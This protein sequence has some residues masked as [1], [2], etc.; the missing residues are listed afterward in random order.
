MIIAY[1]GMGFGILLSVLSLGIF[2][3][4]YL[5]SWGLL[6]GSLCRKVT[7][8]QITAT[9]RFNEFVINPQCLVFGVLGFLGH[10]GDL[11]WAAAFIGS[12]CKP[13]YED[14]TYAYYGTCPYW[15]DWCA[16]GIVGTVGMSIHLIGMV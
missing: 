4:C 5:V 8:R 9:V 13:C 12:Y 15:P 11:I 7:I 6:I 10:V 16:A 2:T 14:D 3:I 1:G